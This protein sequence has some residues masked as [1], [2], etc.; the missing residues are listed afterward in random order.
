MSAAC[1]GDRYRKTVRA[2]EKATAL[3]ALISSLKNVPCMDCCKRFHPVCMDFDHRPGEIKLFTI[4]ARKMGREALL[5]EIAKCDVVCSNCH[6]L[7]THVLRTGRKR[8]T[9]RKGELRS[10]RTMW[11]TGFGEQ[12]I[13]AL[14]A[15]DMKHARFAEAMSVSKPTVSA[16]AN[17]TYPMAPNHIKRASKILGVAAETI[18]GWLHASLLK[19]LGGA[20]GSRR[21]TVSAA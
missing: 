5:A 17:G 19:E 8:K 18:A 20:S 11:C 1:C 3:R 2:K 4:A 13:A 12:L 9:A 16:W 10:S 14:T 21:R 7:R 15:I 6:R